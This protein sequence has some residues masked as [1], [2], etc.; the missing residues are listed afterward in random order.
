MDL[1]EF[2]LWALDKAILAYLA[3][4]SSAFPPS[5]PELRKLVAAETRDFTNELREIERILEANVFHDAD[6]A[7]TE[8]VKAGFEALAKEMGLRGGEPKNAQPKESFEDWQAR[9]KT[10]PLPSLSP[11]ALSRMKGAA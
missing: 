9:F 8:R 7:E 4:T 3:T 10:A 2:P 11:S 6:A 5:S 1:R